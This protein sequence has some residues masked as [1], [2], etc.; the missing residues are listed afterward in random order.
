LRLENKEESRLGKE[1]RIEIRKQRTI[2][3]VKR[4]NKGD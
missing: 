4:N 2:E 3:I 1:R